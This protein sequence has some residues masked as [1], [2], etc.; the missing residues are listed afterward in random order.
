MVRLFFPYY[1]PFTTT[2][3]ILI[4]PSPL[5]PFS[6]RLTASLATGNIYIYYM[7]FAQF[8]AP[9]EQPNVKKEPI[10]E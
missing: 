2:S 10:W 6:S 7:I 5:F 8:E 1:S 3:L 9:K 4:G